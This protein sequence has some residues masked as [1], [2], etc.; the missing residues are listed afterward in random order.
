MKKTIL[1]TILA[2]LA[3]VS[4]LSAQEQGHTIFA[5]QK[6]NTLGVGIC[7]PKAYGISA[8]P[9]TVFFERYAKTVNERVWTGVRVQGYL[10]SGSDNL[11]AINLAKA[12]FAPTVHIALLPEIE[13]HAA[14]YLGYLR[15]NSYGI[16]YSRPMYGTIFG[17]SYTLPGGIG[18]M[19]EVGG[20]STFNFGVLYRF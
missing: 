10:A 15:Q 19:L 8:I 17:A 12:L 13:L 2:I 20:A 11:G 6:A 3:S 7:S 16:V 9:V 18:V 14:P 5:N 4:L 1:T